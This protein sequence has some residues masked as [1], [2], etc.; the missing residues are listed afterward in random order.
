MLTLRAG[1]NLARDGRNVYAR[2]G[3]VMPRQLVLELVP[4]A[5]LGEQIDVVVAGYGERLAVGGE[6]VVCDGMVE[7]MVDVGG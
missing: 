1:D 5:G 6:G 3:L 7:Q 2:N 4:T